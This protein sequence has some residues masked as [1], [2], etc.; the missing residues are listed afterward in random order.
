MDM[1]RDVLNI[2][3]KQIWHL[4]GF[5]SNI[6]DTIKQLAENHDN[7]ILKTDVLSANLA[8]AQMAQIH[9]PTARDL[10]REMPEPATPHNAMQAT[11]PSPNTLFHSP[12]HQRPQA[13]PNRTQQ[14]LPLTQAVDAQAR[15]FPQL[16]GSMPC[17]SSTA[18]T[19]GGS[20]QRT[21]N[22]SS[23]HS[24]QAW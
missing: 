20:P 7:I 14:G 12:A 11:S 2:V 24:L 4:Q 19:R 10:N 8:A 9:S 6:A 13:P 5:D 18:Y 15:L 16:Q 17:R 1:Q 21:P 23:N 22:S 3:S